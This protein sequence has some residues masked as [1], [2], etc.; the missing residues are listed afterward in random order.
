MPILDA[1]RGAQPG[2]VT[3]KNAET[4][5]RDYFTTLLVLSAE[6][7]F[8]PVPDTPYYLFFVDG[9]WQLSLVSPDEW[10]LRAPGPCLGRCLLQPDMTWRIEP[11]T[12]PVSEPTLRDALRASHGGFI[13]L[14]AATDTLE[15][16]LPHY[17]NTLPYYRRL[18]AAGLANSLSRSLKLGGLDSIGTRHWLEA[19]GATALLPART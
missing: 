15:D 11:L 6:F 8:K 7:S 3:V 18:L 1:W 12:N 4:I 17:V 14:L 5:L 19:A 16:G 10:G 2:A 9:Q 13:E